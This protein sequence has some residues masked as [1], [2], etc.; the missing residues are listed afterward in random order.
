MHSTTNF[1]KHNCKNPV[2]QVLIQNFYANFFDLLQKVQPKNILDA[3]CG[4]GV[5]LAKLKEKNIGK[6]LE[7]IDN[8]KTAINI[9]KKEHP[10]LTLKLGSIYELPYK[11][12]SF[13]TIIC[14]EVLEH[15]DNPTKALQE[16]K[17]VSSRHILLSVPNEPWFMMANFLRGKNIKRWGNHPEHIN[18]WSTNSFKKFVEKEGLK[19]E[20]VRRPFAWTI[21]LCRV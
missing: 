3:G 12:N 1:D 4:E 8:F 9:G 7:G 20:E 14:T 11:D 17:R 6:T 19:V 5:T 10:D 18:H 21:L 2:Q 15:L 16:L 13:D